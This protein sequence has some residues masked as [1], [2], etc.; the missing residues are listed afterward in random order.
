MLLAKYLKCK[1]N[2]FSRVEQCSVYLYL[3]QYVRFYLQACLR[4]KSILNKLAFMKLNISSYAQVPISF[5]ALV[6]LGVFVGFP[7][8]PWG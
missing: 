6:L 3:M 7:S 2:L 1:N 8:P 4:K 5:T